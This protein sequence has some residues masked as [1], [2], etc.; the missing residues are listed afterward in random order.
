[1]S[2]QIDHTP[3]S[4]LKVLFLVE[5]FT[6]IRF[7]TGLSEIC[8][9]TMAI[10][11]PQYRLSGLDE[12]ISQAGLRLD[13]DVIE[14]GR[15]AYQ[16]RSL[17]YL[18]RH[19]RDFDVILCQEVLRGAVNGCLVGA[20]TG[21]PAITYMCVPPVEY[22]RCRFERDHSGWFKD[23][24]GTGIIRLLMSWNGMLAR[25]CVALGPYLNQIA[26]AYCPRTVNGLYYGVDTNYYR[27]VTEAEAQQTRAAL[28]LPTDAFVVFLSSRISHE[29]DPETVLRAV[30]LARSRGINA[31]LLN[32][33]GGYQDFL[34]LA[35]EVAGP[36]GDQ[37]VIGRPAAHPTKE[38]AAYY[39]ASDCL[40]QA[41]LAEGLG[42]SPLE[43]MACGTPAVC[44]AVGGL[45]ANLNGYAR[46]T[47][48]RDH[49]A[50]A[51][52]LLW[53]AENRLA[54]RKQALDGREFVIREW[55]REKAFAELAGILQDV[56]RH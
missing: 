24:I 50:M 18:M 48:R 45:G 51:R 52:E 14:G 13:V 33:G 11:G 16:A 10:P 56:V 36:G 2:E 53:V 37:W 32:L 8:D 22:F 46:M 1:M 12:R 30:S 27:P 26:A 31:V 44:T 19:A 40:A 17:R 39:Q 47:P 23:V 34:R 35:R 5:G 28:E 43:A 4:R 54:A 29:K 3:G 9:L 21:T 15:L 49:E 20:L 38:L 25:R 6:D 41:S 42:L 7:V 55:N